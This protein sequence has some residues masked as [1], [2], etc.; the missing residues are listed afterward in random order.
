M[1]TYAVVHGLCEK[2]GF[3]KKIL[4]YHSLEKELIIGTALLLIGIAIGMKVVLTWIGIGFGSPSEI[5][6]K[7]GYSNGACSDRHT[8]DIHGNIFKCVIAERGQL[9]LK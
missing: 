1:K 4:D 3:I 8:D 7:C 2:E 6:R 9:N 5:E